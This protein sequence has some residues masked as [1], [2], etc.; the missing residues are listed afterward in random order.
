MYH[1]QVSP[2]PRDECPPSFSK[3]VIVSYVRAF[4]PKIVLISSNRS[5]SVDLPPFVARGII[6]V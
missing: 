4:P 6:L 5:L 2:T 1:S 3:D